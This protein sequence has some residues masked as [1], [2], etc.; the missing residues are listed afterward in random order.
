MT[1]YIKNFEEFLKKE[2]DHD[3]PKK[4]LRARKILIGFRR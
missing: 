2:L 3:N 4:S 1:D